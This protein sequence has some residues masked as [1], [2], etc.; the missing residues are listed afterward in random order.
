MRAAVIGAGAWGTALADLLGRAGH[1]VALWAYEPEVVRD[2]QRTR[3][4]RMFLPDVTISERITATGD[5]G[6]VAAEA[7]LVVYVPPSHALRRV[8]RSTAP[9]VA[10]SAVLVVATKGIEHGTHAL[11][12]DIVA[13]ETPG[14]SV[15]ALS[16]PTFALEV[17]QQ[18]P[19]AIVAASTDPGAARLV[20]RRCSSAVFRVYTQSDVI[21]VELGG[22]LKNIIA[23]AVGVADGLGLGYNTR[24]ALIT[25]G[26]A[27]M[28]RLG[29]ALGA[30]PATFAGLAGMGDLVL[31]CT[32]PLSRNRTL[33]VRLGQGAALEELLADRATVAEGVPAAESA[34]SLAAE[35]GVEMPIV[36]A[37]HGILFNGLSPR[38]AIGALMERELRHEQ[39]E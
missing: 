16:G 29:V 17:A 4:N 12:T 34:H 15:V 35:R 6:T 26:L 8:A 22:A 28:T 1:E 27:E 21:G 25:R 31:T 10:D 20:Q 36:G 39:E 33:G 14:R 24:A 5:L 13:A 37:V 19:T 7:E 3:V 30:N 11:M 23:V 18:Q 38:D 2:I 9:S 32:G